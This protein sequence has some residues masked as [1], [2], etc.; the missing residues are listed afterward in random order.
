MV[1]NIYS[2]HD[3]YIQKQVDLVNDLFIS[4]AQSYQDRMHVTSGEHN[5]C[6]HL[7]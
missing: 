2:T 5:E 6:K 3:K 7:V 1:R 4:Q